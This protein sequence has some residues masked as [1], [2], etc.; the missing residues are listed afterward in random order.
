MYADKDVAPD[1]GH[2]RR[3]STGLPISGNPLWSSGYSGDRTA[4]PWHT[5]SNGWA[6]RPGLTNH[7]QEAHKE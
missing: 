1:R 5:D 6:D 3:R 7:K 2:Q 4:A